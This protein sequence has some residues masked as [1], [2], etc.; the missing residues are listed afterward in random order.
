MK[1]NENQ[2][3]PETKGIETPGNVLIIKIKE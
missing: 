1:G 2:T 3:E